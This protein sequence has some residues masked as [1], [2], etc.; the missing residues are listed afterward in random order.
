MITKGDKILIFFTLLVAF[1]IF[2]GFQVYGFCEGKTY[3]IIEVDGEVFQKISLGEKGPN[4][5]VKIPTPLGENIVE[6]NG[7]RVR[8]LMA[9]CPD[10]ACV[11]QGWISKPGQIIVCLPHQ[12]IVRIE[13]D[14]SPLDP[15]DAVSF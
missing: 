14:K 10:E 6:I 1:L 15:V 13:R 2:A 5:Q 9:D 11:R 7:Q 4:L 12:I 3:A 8:M